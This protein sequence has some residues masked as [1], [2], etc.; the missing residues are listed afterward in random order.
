MEQQVL[1]DEMVRV[2]EAVEADLLLLPH[3]DFV[4]V[5]FRRGDERVV[6]VALGT[7]RPD[8]VLALLLTHVVPVVARHL[9]AHLAEGRWQPEFQVLKGRTRDAL[10]L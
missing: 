10:H 8:L 2:R 7:A 5:A 6:L 4:S 9:V 1:T 3:V